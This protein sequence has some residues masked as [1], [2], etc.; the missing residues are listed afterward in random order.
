MLEA[1]SRST[2]SPAPGDR[3]EARHRILIISGGG[4]W[5]AFGEG[6]LKGWKSVSAQNPLAMPEFD[7]VTGVSAGT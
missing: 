4:D 3:K 6:F 1:P 7:A 5:G 2:T